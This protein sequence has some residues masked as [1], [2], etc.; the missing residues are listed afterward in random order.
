VGFTDDGGTHRLRVLGEREMRMEVG[1]VWVLK[2][3][4][5]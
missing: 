4:S 5:K 2:T 3:R 1:W